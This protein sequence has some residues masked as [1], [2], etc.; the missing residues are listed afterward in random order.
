MLVPPVI[1]YLCSERAAGLGSRSLSSYHASLSEASIAA[2]GGS[3]RRGNRHRVRASGRRTARSSAVHRSLREDGCWTGL[4]VA[5]GAAKG[6]VSGDLGSTQALHSA[7]LRSE[8]VD[9][10]V[11]PPSNCLAMVRAQGLPSRS[12]SRPSSW[13]R[14]AGGRKRTGWWS[15]ARP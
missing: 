13:D 14:G 8:Q 6:S 12:L 11:E 10:L 2:G 5:E 7:T 3:R 4:I 15:K 9:D 1:S